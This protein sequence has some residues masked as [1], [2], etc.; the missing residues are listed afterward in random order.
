MIWFIGLVWL[1]YFL[2]QI[3]GTYFLPISWMKQKI[4]NYLQLE[5]LEKSTWNY[6]IVFSLIFTFFV[7]SFWDYITHRWI[8]HK[9]AFWILHEYHHLS[10]IVMNGIPGVHSRPFGFV[11]TALTYIPTSLTILA[12]LPHFLSSQECKLFILEGI[13]L[14]SMILIFI[15]CLIHSSFL[16]KFKSVH[17]F[18][19]I[20]LVTSPHEHYLHHSSQRECNFGNF[21]TL[22]DRLFRS[23]VSPLDI[24]LSDEK[25]GLKYDQDYLGTLCLGKWKISKENRL[26]YR[27]NET[28]NIDL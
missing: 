10:K 26:K 28:L 11:P 25:M 16:R 19:S 17:R 14:F 21:S 1:L 8:L 2:L 7:L 12:I 3:L 4:W 15:L 20:L 23:Y 24:T 5:T 27:L 18:F 9:K 6:R 13:Q 22:W